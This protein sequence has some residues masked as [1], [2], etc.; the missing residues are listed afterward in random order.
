MFIIQV[1]TVNK[2]GK[3]G[4]HMNL[5]KRVTAMVL[6]III[7]FINSYTIFAVEDSEAEIVDIQ[8]EYIQAI[9]NSSNGRFSIH[10]LEGSPYRNKDQDSKLLFLKDEPETSFTTFKI[11]GKDYIYGNNYSFAGLGNGFTSKPTTTGMTSQSKWKV[12]DMEVTQTLE[13]IDNIS[14]KNVGNVKISYTAKNTGNTSAEIGARILLDTMLG[15]NDAAPLVI[16]QEDN[17]IRFER[18]FS[19]EKVPDYWRSVDSTTNPNVVSYGLVNLPLREKPDK[20]IIAHWNGLSK[21]KW[22]YT[23]NPQSSFISNNND[24]GTADSAIGLYWNPV[25][26]GAGESKVFETFYGLGDFLQEQESNFNLSINAPL[27]LSLDKE[28]YLEKEF[29]VYSE[30]DNTLSKSVD[31]RGLNLALELPEGLVLAEG[32]DQ[33]KTIDFIKNGDIERVEWRVIPNPAYKLRVLELKVRAYSQSIEEVSKNRFIILPGVGTELPELYYQGFMPGMLYGKDEDKAIHIMGKGLE[34]LTNLDNWELSLENKNSGQRYYATRN[35]ISIVNGKHISIKM[36]QDIE[37]GYYSVKIN[38]Q[39]YGSYTFGSLLGVS[40]DSSLASKDYG[41]LTISNSGGS[42]YIARMT[43]NEADIDK[44]A[45]LTIRGKVREIEK[46]KIYEV[47]P[48]D[49]IT[50]N[51]VVKYKGNNLQVYKEG[52]LFKLKGE[53]SLSINTKASGKSIDLKVQSGKFVLDSENRTFTSEDGYVKYDNFKNVGGLPL[54]INTVKLDGNNVKIA[55][56]LQLPIEKISKLFMGDYFDSLGGRLDNIGINSSGIEYVGEIVIPFPRWKIGSFESKHSTITLSIN[57]K[58]DHY[59]I[60]TVMK[61]RPL[62]LNDI[63]TTLMFKNWEPQYLQFSNNFGKTPKPIGT[64]GLGFQKIGGGIY[65]IDKIYKEKTPTTTIVATCDIV[66]LVS[67]FKIKGYPL[68]TGKDITAT[69]DLWGID[70]TG[71]AY[72][73]FVDVGDVN[74]GFSYSGGWIEA[75][76]NL[77]DIL[78]IEG[79]LSVMQDNVEGYFNGNIYFPK[80]LPLVGGKKL[81]GFNAGMSLEKIWGSTK[82]LGCGIGVKYYWKDDDIDIDVSLPSLSDIFGM[83]DQLLYPIDNGKGLYTLTGTSKNGRGMTV[84]YGSNF[85]RIENRDSLL[86]YNGDMGEFSTKALYSYIPT[87]G[88]VHHVDISGVETALI[89]IGYEGEAPTIDVVD[90][91]GNP[92]QLINYEDDEINANYINQVISAEDSDTGEEEKSIYISIP[93]VEEGTWIVRSNK[94]ILVNLFNV[95]EVPEFVSLVVEEDEWG[96]K[97][98]KW[99]L[100]TDKDSKISLYLTKDNELSLDNLLMKDIDASEGECYFG[101]D[102]AISGDYQIVAVVTRED[103]GYNTAISN[104]FTVNNSSME[105]PKGFKVEPIGNGFLR[106]SWDYDLYVGSHQL[107]GWVLQVVDENGNVDASVGDQILIPS[108]GNTEVLLGGVLADEK[109]NPYGWFTDREY[110]FSLRTVG[111]S[112]SG[113]EYYYSLPAIVN[114]VYLPDPDRAIIHTEI[115]SPNGEVTNAGLYDDIP[116]KYVNSSLV[117][118]DIELDKEAQIRIYHEGNIVKSFLGTEDSGLIS[119]NSG[120]NEIRIEAETEKG[121]LSEIKYIVIS[122]TE[123]PYLMIESPSQTFFS[124]EATFLVSGKTEVDSTLTINGQETEVDTDGSFNEIMTLNG[125]KETL[126]F[127]A[128]DLA[129]NIT[130][131]VAEV[132]NNSTDEIIGITIEPSNVEIENGDKKQLELFGIT[133]NGETITLDSEVVN[134]EIVQGIDIGS[135]VDGVFTAKGEGEVILK[136]SYY[137]RDDFALEDAIVVKIIPQTS[138]PPS[139]EVI[140]D[141]K[142]EPNIEEI[143]KGTSQKFQLSGTTNYNNKSYLNSDKVNWEIIGN[144]NLATIS[145]NGVLF[146]K[147]KGE[148]TLKATHIN[149][150]GDTS[151]DQINIRI[152]SVDNTEKNKRERVANKDTLIK[153]ANKIA[154]M[155]PSGALSEGDYVSVTELLNTSGYISNIEYLNPV[156]QMFEINTTKDY[157]FKKEVEIEITYDKNKVKDPS[158]L[159]IYVYNETTNRWDLVGGEVDQEN[160][161][162]KVK[163]NHFSVYG[164]FE[165]TQQIMKD[166]KG[167]WAEDIVNNLVSMGIISGIRTSE[168]E[169]IYN[170]EGDITRAEFSKLLAG[171]M[172]FK[173]QGNTREY[174]K[175]SVDW[176]DVPIWAQPYMD[177]CFNQGWITGE[178]SV[179]GKY[180]MPNKAITRAEAAAM[181]GRTL[182]DNSKGIENRFTD[183]ANIPDWA[184]EHINKLVALKII[185]GYPDGRFRPEKTFS[186]A[187]GAALIYQYIKH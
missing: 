26:L 108:T 14:N 10:T 44:S 81:S 96:A 83:N 161:T 41:I 143:Y 88:L 184:K 121:D 63:N 46:D 4:G 130:T 111:V 76:L 181:I 156:S 56:D 84:V 160:N 53:G 36:P 95:K 20:F 131:Y 180:L 129:G 175:I 124:N 106:A 87:T 51:S 85:E 35:N 112:Y 38:H 171:I 93:N 91:N 153:L 55:G 162:I 65:G 125:M 31:L 64:T 98:A 154:I 54:V 110:N 68:F 78:I 18:E 21:S 67:P 170:P 45:V 92:F 17:P 60:K 128:E 140:I 132:W 109:G 176:A 3:G 115:T 61:N 117:S 173:S 137:I 8:N 74:G 58:T 103:F 28:G 178:D 177:Y 104:S 152:L 126:S 166:M 138:M 149:S 159:G 48:N 37:S 66:D 105:I 114:N 47:I 99:S 90:P 135:I 75:N 40:N 13:I 49:T 164:V 116:A 71:D 172:D 165:N 69:I 127:K 73:Y 34:L 101:V 179:E 89:Q 70:F 2:R 72:I 183:E 122:D 150:E 57:T 42:N 147:Q 141:V 158:K 119:L 145:N 120:I 148:I 157:E 186:R 24:Y 5:Y 118:L 50:I 1:W 77:A 15:N 94:E 146:A 9:V 62:M 43:D 12:G 30:V 82:F 79:Y 86:A 32:E 29:I 80:G 168:S 6:S 187:E 151:V 107:D 102:N 174:S 16:P 27:K 22:D 7:I 142:I 19:G 134:W 113:D 59:G 139:K 23:V 169:F 163:V 123:A 182:L 155:I 136:A 52:S 133:E 97:K 11:N 100:N 25:T 33:I 185:K 39:V 167:H 144:S